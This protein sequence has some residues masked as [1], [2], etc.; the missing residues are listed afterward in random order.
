MYFASARK[1]K[2]SQL[3]AVVLHVTAFLF[4]FQAT[5]LCQEYCNFEEI[6]Y[7][8]YDLIHDK[9]K[10]VSSVKCCTLLHPLNSLAPVTVR[11]HHIIC[12]QRKEESSGDCLSTHYFI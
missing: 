2:K 3:Q 5:V 6:F 9:V 11:V 8:C 7:Y 1:I 10:N 4:I 12:Q